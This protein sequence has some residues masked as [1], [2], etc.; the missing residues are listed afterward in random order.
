M[1]SPE[2]FNEW[3]NSNSFREDRIK[4]ESERMNNVS[5]FLNLYT[6]LT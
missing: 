6:E 3:R 4:L 2:F 5:A 1:P